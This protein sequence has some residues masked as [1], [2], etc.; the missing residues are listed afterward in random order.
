MQ[1]GD[2]SFIF[3]VQGA[4]L[5]AQSLI[6]ADSLRRHHPHADLIAYLPGETAADLPPVIADFLADCGVQCRSLEQPEGQW[7]AP[8][9]HGNKILALAAPRDSRWSMFLDTDMAALGPIDPTDLPGPMQVSVVPEG[10]ATWGKDLT[11]WEVAYGFFGLPM[12][13]DR[14]R[15]L[16]GRRLMFPPYFNGGMVAIREADRV[17]GLSFGGLWRDTAKAFDWQARV[18]HKRPWL[19]QI[20]LPLTMQRHGFAH[21]IIDERTN[22]SISNNR[23]LDGLNPTILHYHR[24]GFLRDWPGHAHLTEAVLDRATTAQQ[25]EIAALLTESGFLGPLQDK[26]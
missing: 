3:V 10:I 21:K 15:L 14:I 17:D 26:D 23:K 25:P 12:P 19:D 9:P 6:L 16:R 5:Q 13:E 4:R 1:P 22:C 18:A 20:T 8:Y 11:R 7:R 2:L 24:A